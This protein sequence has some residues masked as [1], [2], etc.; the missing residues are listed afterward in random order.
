[1]GMEKVY[2]NEDLIGYALKFNSQN[3]EPPRCIDYELCCK[4]P[5]P[6]TIKKRFG[7]WNKYLEKAGFYP[8]PQRGTPY[9]R[10]ERDEGILFDMPKK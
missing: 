6:S 3:G 4:Y 8:R 5:D 9:S 7:S 2:T 1:M 10:M